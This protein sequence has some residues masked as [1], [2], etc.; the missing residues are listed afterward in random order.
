MLAPQHLYPQELRHDLTKE[1]M[2][3]F[4]LWAAAEGASD[5][6]ICPDD[7]LWIQLHG[8]WH[9]AS[10]LQVT[11]AESSLLVSAFAQQDQAGARI[12]AADSLD[13]A[14]SIRAGRG[15]SQRFRVNG[16]NTERGP[17][18]VMRS[19]PRELPILSNFEIEPDILN[20]IFP[21]NG[22]VIIS[23]VMGS[24]KSTLLAAVLNDAA[25][26]VGRQILTLEEP[27]E[28]DFS[29]IHFENRVAP[30]GQSGI[31]QHVKSWGAGVRTMTRRK[32]EIVLVG[33]ARDEETLSGMLAAVE[34]GVTAY[35]T[36]HAQDVPQ[37]I[38]RIVN[39]FPLD[40]RGAVSAVLKTNLRLI[41]HQRLVQR[42]DKQGR[43]PL[44][45]YLVFTEDI[46][47]IL[48][49]TSYDNLVPTL[50]KLTEQH[51]MTL[52]NDAEKKY[53]A[54]IISENTYLAVKDEQESSFNNLQQKEG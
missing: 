2:D 28:F 22:L 47:R 26:R 36:V 51:G 40:A 9:I 6:V 14:Y 48:H 54:K 53:K 8:I 49:L 16:T 11:A 35:S 12:H 4:L 19:L 34:Q 21:P 37:T 44:R 29:S 10:T 25:K 52:L 46:R 7:P 18:I 31:G 1:M 39:A 42:I 23:G 20:N 43:I 38:T 41:V 32:G 27:I 24:G 45:E 13:F 3:G 17:Y 50:R 15:K 33:E 5:V 30:I